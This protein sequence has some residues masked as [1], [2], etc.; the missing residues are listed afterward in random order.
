MFLEELKDITTDPETL[1]MIEFNKNMLTQKSTLFRVGLQKY[2]EIFADRTRKLEERKQR[3][4]AREN[5]LALGKGGANLAERLRETFANLIGDK[6]Q[7][8]VDEIPS[9]QQYIKKLVINSG[10]MSSY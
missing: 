8:I 2:K 6:K 5:K 4:K 10:Y 1:E 7:E 9:E 3:K